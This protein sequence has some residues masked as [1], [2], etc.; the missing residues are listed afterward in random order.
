M[1]DGLI[2]M[3][4]QATKSNNAVVGFVGGIVL[5]FTLT[6]RKII[7]GKDMVKLMVENAELKTTK[8]HIEA[9]L[10]EAKAEIEKLSKE[11][12]RA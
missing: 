6:A 4:E 8:T 3:V 9:E 12:G 1:S 2:D 11:L 10:A 5:F 7:F